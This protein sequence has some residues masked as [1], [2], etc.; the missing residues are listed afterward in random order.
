[1]ILAATQ[2]ITGAQA[3]ISRET[4]AKGIRTVF[5]NVD[6]REDP[7]RPTAAF[8]ARALFAQARE[9][10]L[11]MMAV[12]KEVVA[13][14]YADL[15]SGDKE[16]SR[17]IVG[18]MFPAFCAKVR[19]LSARSRAKVERSGSRVLYPPPRLPR[20]PFGGPTS[21]HGYS[22]LVAKQFELHRFT[23]R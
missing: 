2:A 23:F 14:S 15:D 11:D 6:L 18:I 22:E 12:A 13:V 8:L 10:K 3:G 7:E 1:M 19:R 4:L 17:Q 21:R 9:M 16:L 20:N 5:S